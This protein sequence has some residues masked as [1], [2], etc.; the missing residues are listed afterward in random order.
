MQVHLLFWNLIFLLPSIVRPK[1]L[2]EVLT[3]SPT[4]FKVRS[5]LITKTTYTDIYSEE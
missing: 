5:I 1:W 2:G 4:Q 3:D